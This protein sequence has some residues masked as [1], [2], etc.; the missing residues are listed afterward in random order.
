MFHKDDSAKYFL[1]NS[2]IWTCD[3]CKSM[4]CHICAHFGIDFP[5][6]HYHSFQR[7]FCLVSLSIRKIKHKSNMVFSKDC[8]LSLYMVVSL[9][10]N[11]GPLR[12]N[13]VLNSF[14]NTGNVCKYILYLTT[15]MYRV[16]VLCVFV[17]VR[18]MFTVCLP[19][20]LSRFIPPWHT[21]THTHTHTRACTLEVWVSLMLCAVSVWLMVWWSWFDDSISF[22]GNMSLVW[23]PQQFIMCLFL[24]VTFGCPLEGEWAAVF[25]LLQ[26]TVMRALG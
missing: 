1:Y 19:A 11:L 23:L 8:C 9:R 16:C 15:F 4:T 13:E 3:I 25:L 17:L 12:V 2:E 7:L 10:D 18:E 6:L 24:S 20:L 26:S 14:D 5:L 22:N 21:H